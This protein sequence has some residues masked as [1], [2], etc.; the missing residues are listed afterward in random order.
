MMKRLLA[1]AVALLITAAAALT[2]LLVRLPWPQKTPRETGSFSAAVD[3]HDR[4][5]ND[6]MITDWLKEQ[7]PHVSSRGFTEEQYARGQAV[8]TL[9]QHYL[10]MRVCNNWTDFVKNV[11]DIAE[12]TGI[13][14]YNQKAYEKLYS[15]FLQRNRIKSYNLREGRIIDCPYPENTVAAVGEPLGDAIWES[16]RVIGGGNG[17]YTV[18]GNYYW[19]CTTF[20]WARFYEVYGFSSGARGNGCLHA[21]EIVRAHPQWFRITYYPVPGATFSSAG[22]NGNP[23]GHVGFIEAVQD[24][25]LWVS[26]GNVGT[27]G[28]IRFNYKMSIEEFFTR[29]PSVIFASPIGY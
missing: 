7:Q 29:Y 28:G 14:K 4:R 17:F 6:Q 18:N 20:A 16:Y 23:A 5:Y 11:D 19:Q 3:M 12:D 1:V 2:I 22:R 26:E 27:R 25:Y 13:L 10:D 8:G 21:Q 24:G 9:L 15:F